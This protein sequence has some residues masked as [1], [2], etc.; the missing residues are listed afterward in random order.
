M[1]VVG[2]M[3]KRIL[4]DGLTPDGHGP[5]NL[6]VTV[7]GLGIQSQPMSNL[8]FERNDEQIHINLD[9]EFTNEGT[10]NATV[11][12]IQVYYGPPG[13]IDPTYHMLS[14]D[15]PSTTVPINYSL[16]VER[17]TLLFFEGVGMAAIIAGDGFREGWDWRTI[18]KSPTGTNLPGS[19]RT[20]DD[21]VFFMDSPGDEALG[22]SPKMIEGGPIDYVN[23]TT[24]N[25]TAAGIEFQV[26]EGSNTWRAFELGFSETTILPNQTLRLT[27]LSCTFNPTP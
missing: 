9:M 15:I 17:I 3:F 20:Y 11:N 22:Q 19:V 26:S 1:A 27:S 18:L 21:Q 14:V 12:T 8:D 24:N 2:R 5:M 4:L 25:W 10:Q 16:K 13:S 7:A 6:N 23:G